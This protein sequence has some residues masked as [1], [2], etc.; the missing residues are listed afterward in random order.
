MKKRRR[1]SGYLVPHILFNQ[2]PS[3]LSH[4]GTDIDR[5]L[6]ADVR[7]DVMLVVGTS[8]KTDGTYRLVKQMSENVREHGGIVIYIDNSS[9]GKKLASLFDMQIQVE[10]EDWA[11]AM[12]SFP[13]KVSTI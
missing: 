6:T 12:L 10:I 3:E 5:L 2:Q 13:F 4:N 8:L 9:A 1:K 11:D 7:V